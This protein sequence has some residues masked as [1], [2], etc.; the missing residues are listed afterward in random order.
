MMETSQPSGAPREQKE[1]VFRCLW[2]LVQHW[3]GRNYEFNYFALKYFGMF[4]VVDWRRQLIMNWQLIWKLYRTTTVTAPPHYLVTSLFGSSVH[5]SSDIKLARMVSLVACGVLTWLTLPSLRM[6]NFRICFLSS[7]LHVRQLLSCERCR[8]RD[9]IAISCAQLFQPR[10]WTHPSIDQCH[11]NLQK[12]LLR[13]GHVDIGD[14][15]IAEIRQSLWFRCL[16]G[17]W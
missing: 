17:I 15:V 16:A 11:L 6:V 1:F 7:A 2:R 14:R 10:R 8:M 4:T 5:N 12:T 3:S 13:D 9:K